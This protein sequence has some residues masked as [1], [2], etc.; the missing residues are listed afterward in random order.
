M[1]RH[2][3][4]AGVALSAVLAIGM[5]PQKKSAEAAAGNEACA[6]CHAEIAQSYSR[7]IMAR[8]SG[9]ASDGLITGDFLHQKS[10]VRYRIF[11]RDNRTWM[12]YERDGQTG[13]RGER[14][15]LY[16]IGS[17]EKGRSYLFSRQGFL[18]ETPTNWYSQE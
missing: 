5:A 10:G 13:F 15:L 9:I 12:S 3:A 16:F 1:G 2:A 11:Q 14:E 4:I 8:A 6:G 18:F 7:T 17:G